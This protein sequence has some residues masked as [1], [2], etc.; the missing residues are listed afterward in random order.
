[1]GLIDRE[2]IDFLLFDVLGIA[3]VC[4]HGRY[5]DHDRTSLGAVLDLAQRLS[6][7]TLW[8]IAALGDTREPTLADGVVSLPPEVNAALARLRD[9]GF[10]AAHADE[11]EGGMQLP[12]TV[13][14]ACNGMMKGANVGVHAYMSLTRAAG[15]LLR[16]HGTDA[17][18]RLYLRPMLEGR[19]FGTMCLSEPD[20]GSSLADIRTRATPSGKGEYAITGSKM[21]ISGGDHDAAEN[22]VHLVLAR[23]PDAP[24]GVSGI[25]LFA[26]PRIRVNHDGTVGARNGVRVAGLNHKMGY[27]AT[28][29]C[30]LAFG[31]EEPA[32]GTLVGQPHKGLAAMFHMMNEARISVG[33]GAAM[34][35][36]V[37]YRYALGYARERLQGR[38]P[39]QRDPAKPPVPLAAHADVRRMLLR[40]KAF[41]E[42]GIALCL[43]AGTLVDRQVLTE[44]AT[45]QDRLARLLDLLTPVV[46]A[47][48][49]EFG[50]EANRDAIQVL[51]GYGY[52]R[53]FPVERLYRDNRLNMIH[54]GTNG[55]QA[56]DLLGRKVLGKGAGN[57]DLLEA[58]IRK[59]IADAAGAAAYVAETEALLEAFDD[60]RRTVGAVAA[61]IESEGRARGVA[62][63]SAFLNGFGHVVVGWLLLRSALTARRKADEQGEAPFLQ[64]KHA[65]CAFF[66]A[67]EMPVARA[68]LSVA[69][70][71]PLAVS[72][73]SDAA[74]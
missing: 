7:E 19:F 32:L 58:E 23:L 3:E 67:H 60:V 68:W 66:F 40:Q 49:S 45:E 52:S 50:L 5:A 70:A 72:D 15:N 56:L 53:E 74:L 6:Q 17:Q 57:I 4:G 65:A 33:I 39:G 28:S 13:N 47:W 29:N 51:G 22:I 43:F 44:D 25:S 37:G 35:A 20:A 55:I 26:V 31:E 30:L 62:H 8:P 46:K 54:E 14:H 27:R 12:V 38:L 24:P 48:P 10:F 63:A 41:S 61:R 21:W 36:S 18:K 34:L 73:T 2:T 64:G 69:R 1:M 42:G 9:A 11:A 59:S 71:A 16:T